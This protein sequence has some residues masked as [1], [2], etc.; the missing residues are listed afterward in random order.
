[1]L[2]GLQRRTRGIACYIIW[3][4]TRQLRQSWN[5][6]KGCWKGSLRKAFLSICK[7]FTAKPHSTPP[8]SKP[9]NPPPKSSSSILLPATSRLS[10]FFTSSPLGETPLHYSV[11]AGSIELVK[12]LL[13]HGADPLVISHAN[14]TAMD[15]ASEYNQLEIYDYL[16]S[17]EPTPGET[18][19]DTFSDSFSFQL[20]NPS[21]SAS[22]LGAIMP[23]SSEKDLETYFIVG[24][25]LQELEEVYGF[26]IDEDDELLRLLLS[27]FAQH[28][29]TQDLLRWSIS[30]EIKN[31]QSGPTLFRGISVATKLL[32]LYSFDRLG[33]KYLKKTLLSLVSEVT[34]C[35][36]SFEIDPNKALESGCIDVKKNLER[37]LNICQELLDKIFR[38][39]EKFPLPIRALFRYTREEVD[40]KFPEMQRLAIGGLLF[41]RFL[42]PAI[43]TPEKY[44]LISAPPST[45]SRRTLILIS[46]IL[47]NL[48]NAVQ[49]D[50]SKEAYMM[51]IDNFIVE[52]LQAVNNFFD[53]LTSVYIDQVTLASP[54]Y[55]FSHDSSASSNLHEFFLTKIDQRVL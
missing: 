44:G 10:E 40:K 14:E 18:K 4:E 43:V 48:A 26:D 7:I 55:Q 54:K 42:C 16:S 20:S 5:G 6:L 32:G 30:R 39:Y 21:R 33:L 31:T 24:R 52:N 41:L 27:F 13:K 28:N 22:R 35:K 47:Q 3:F 25:G 23:L 49:F 46:K 53:N 37:L 36:A 51:G 19:E 8:A 38:T 34:T 50:G 2:T 29:K 11:R 17:A 1:M 15:V 9:T 12:L 45:E